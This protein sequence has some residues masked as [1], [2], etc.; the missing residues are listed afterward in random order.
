[1]EDNNEKILE[2]I[3]KLL[4]MAEKGTVNEKKTAMIKAQKLMLDHRIEMAEV[5]G[6]KKED[7]VEIDCS[8]KVNCYSKWIMD[9]SGIITK[10]FRCHPAYCSYAGYKGKVKTLMIIGLK[11]DAEICCEVM[12]FAVEIANKESKKVVNWYNKRGFSSAGIKQDFMEGFISGIKEGF[13]QQIISNNKYAVAVVV[14]AE[15]NEHCRQYEKKDIITKS[16]KSAGS[17]EAK[18]FGYQTGYKVASGTYD[19]KIIEQNMLGN[20]TSDEKGEKNEDNYNFEF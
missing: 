15:V 20:K 10:N 12:E 6:V 11:A 16:V 5:L 8:W 3:H 13:Y 2:K 14:P 18:H 17:D 19:Q 7:I 9:L 1:M 4:S